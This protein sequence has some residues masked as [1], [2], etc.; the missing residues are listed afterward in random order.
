MSFGT[1]LRRAAYIGTEE[2]GMRMRMLM[3]PLLAGVLASAGCDLITA[4]L[5]AEQTAN[6]QKSYPISANGT[7][8]IENVNG[9]IEVEPS[10]G[11]T[12]EVTAVKKARG[13]SDEAAK[14]A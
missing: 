12:V 5:R 2:N 8:D 1:R 9:K 13:A 10:S 11:S 6:W 7:V 14:A 3:I 4:D